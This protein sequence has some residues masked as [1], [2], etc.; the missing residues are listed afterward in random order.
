MQKLS[1]KEQLRLVRYNCPDVWKKIDEEKCPS[2]FNLKDVEGCLNVMDNCATC[3]N[4]ALN[5]E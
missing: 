2:D 4:A 1:I 3:R 5:G